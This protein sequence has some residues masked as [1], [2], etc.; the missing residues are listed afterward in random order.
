MRHSAQKHLCT[1]CK[2]RAEVSGTVQAQ[3]TFSGTF[4]LGAYT[5]SPLQVRA[6]QR[7]ESGATLRIGVIFLTNCIYVQC[8]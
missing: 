7:E 1:C 6:Q 8:F 2:V 4:Y 5:A 3:R